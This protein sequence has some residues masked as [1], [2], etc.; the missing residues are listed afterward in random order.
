MAR[1]RDE[2]VSG[3]GQRKRS[4]NSRAS[5][6]ARCGGICRTAT[7]TTNTACTRASSSTSLRSF[8]ASHTTRRL[9]WKSWTSWN[10][11]RADDVGR[12]YDYPH[13]VAAYW[14]LYHVARNTK[15]LTTKHPWDW[16]LNQAYETSLAMCSQAPYYTRLRP[17][18]GHGLLRLLAD[19]KAEGWTDQD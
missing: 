5:S 4:R 2:G 3:A 16:Y 7:A 9:N 12:S 1:C 6:T 19:L 18:G 11:K 10:K 8:L 13:V 14:S 15:G 17:D